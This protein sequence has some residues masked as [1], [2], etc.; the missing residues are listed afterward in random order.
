MARRNG[1]ARRGLTAQI[2]IARKQLGLDDET[3]RQMISTTTNGKRSCADCS[4]RELEQIVARLKAAGFEARPR[5]RV[6][7]HPG[8]PHNLEREPQL[9]KI[10]ALL[11]EMKLT[12]SY[13]D[14]IA[15][16]QFGVEKVAWLRQQRELSA[17]IAALHVELEK[18]ALLSQVDEA[19]E[20]LGTSREAFAEANHQSLP[21]N[22]TRNRRVLR[23]LLE[24]LAPALPEQHKEVSA[25]D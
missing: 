12:W 15:R 22:W 7:Q 2:H 20:R 14:A 6:A 17:V 23:Q 18:R 1:N 25:N 11:S 3:Y 24:E 4:V 19:L 16:R 8:T 21:G 9:Q 13:A 5:K 10:E